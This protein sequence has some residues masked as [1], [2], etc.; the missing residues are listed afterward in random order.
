MSL[1][2]SGTPSRS[3]GGGRATHRPSPSPRDLTDRWDS[4]P[5]LSNGRAHPMTRASHHLPST[6]RSE[7]PRQGRLSSN[8]RGGRSSTPSS[9]PVPLSKEGRTPIRPASV[10]GKW[11]PFPAG[12][13]SLGLVLPPPLSGFSSCGFCLGA[14]R[15]CVFPYL[16]F[17]F[18]PMAVRPSARRNAFASFGRSSS[19]RAV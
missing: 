18:L 12:T 5:C 15:S 4:G 16:P 1:N 19:S 8:V 9:H 11:R 7:R 13:T 6:R 2:G 14:K 3:D 10:R 17:F